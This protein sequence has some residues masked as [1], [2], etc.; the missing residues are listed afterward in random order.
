[1]RG[2]SHCYLIEKLIQSLIQLV[3]VCG[4]IFSNTINVI[5]V[6]TVYFV[7]LFGSNYQ[8]V[9]LDTTLEKQLG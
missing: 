8:N 6:D 1:M 7:G 4:N 5:Y 3:M 2:V 9:T